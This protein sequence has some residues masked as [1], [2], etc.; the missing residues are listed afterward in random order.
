MTIYAVTFR[1]RIHKDQD[2]KLAVFETR[3]DAERWLSKNRLPQCS[4][5]EIRTFKSLLAAIVMDNALMA[6][7]KSKDALFEHIKSKRKSAE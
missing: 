6:H 7:L 3:K 4:V 2:K 5:V 1:N